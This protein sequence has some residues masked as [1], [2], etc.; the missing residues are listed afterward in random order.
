MYLKL[1]LLLTFYSKTFIKPLD[2]LW[3]FFAG[4]PRAKG[5]G[6]CRTAGVP[7]CRRGPSSTVQRMV[8]CPYHTLPWMKPLDLHQDSRSPQHFQTSG[9]QFPSYPTWAQIQF[10]TNPSLTCPAPKDLKIQILSFASSS[11]SSS[12]L[13]WLMI[14]WETGETLY[15]EAFI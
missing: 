13:F 4:P 11:S 14:F 2:W 6:Q 7:G 10:A 12:Y 1:T 5:N 3:L 15:Q 8:L 9:K